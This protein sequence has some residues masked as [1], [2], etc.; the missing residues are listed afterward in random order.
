MKLHESIDH[1]AHIGCLNLV[2]DG[3]KCPICFQPVDSSTISK[4]LRRRKAHVK[5]KIYALDIIQ[6]LDSGDSIAI[7][8]ML[9]DITVTELISGLAEIHVKE[10]LKKQLRYDQKN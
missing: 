5:M 9:A 8:T 3:A 7:S 1:Y 4:S 2:E 6:V 10:K